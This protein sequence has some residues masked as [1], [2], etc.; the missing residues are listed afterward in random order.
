M[1]NNNDTIGYTAQSEPPHFLSDMQAAS[2]EHKNTLELLYRSFATGLRSAK[3]VEPR[4]YLADLGLDYERIP[5]AFCSG[6]YH[7][8]KT[9]E[10]LQPLVD[11]GFLKVSTHPANQGRKAYDSFGKYALIFPMRDEQERIVSFQGLRIGL[12][13]PKWE[14]L[15][16][17]GLYPGYPKQNTRRLYITSDI[18]D[19]VSLMQSGVMDNRDA[20]LALHRDNT[21]TDEHQRAIERLEKGCEIILLVVNKQESEK[22]EPWLKEK[23]LLHPVSR[24]L[25]PEGEHLNSMLVKYGGESIQQI[26]SERTGK[27]QASLSGEEHP[28]E[29][30]QHDVS[31]KLNSNDPNNLIYSNGSFIAEV[32]GGIQ[33]DEF[34]RLRVVA[35]VE[36]KKRDQGPMEYRFNCDLYH[37]HLIEQNIRKMADIWQL[38]RNTVKQFISELIKALEQYRTREASPYDAGEEVMSREEAM[39][40]KKYLS[41]DKLMER[42]L[43]D[44]GRAGVVGELNNRLLM[45]MV[46]TSRKMK[47]PLHIITIG[48]SGTGKTYL[49]EKIAEFIPEEDKLDITQLSSNAL[50]YFSR[51]ELRNKLLLIEDLDGAQEALY[52]LRELQTKQKLTKTT[53]RK[54]HKGNTRSV[55]YTVEGPVSIAACT[56]R[57]RLY[58]DNANRAIIIHLDQ[59]KEQDER[60]QEYLKRKSAGMVDLKEEQDTR[61]FL[62][63]SQRLLQPI[64]VINPFALELSLQHQVRKPRRMMGI[65][66]ALIEAIA[67]YHQHQRE[68]KTDT[69]G[70]PYIEAVREDIDWAVKLLKD[71]MV[72]RSDDIS[73]EERRFLERT[74]AYL[75]RLNITTFRAKELVV[76]FRLNAMTVNRYLR[77]LENAAYIER[78][79]GDRK[80][81]FEYCIADR[82][83][84]SLMKQS[85]LAVSKPRRTSLTEV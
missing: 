63:N 25:V 35:R 1:D 2:H 27:I 31:P 84:Y 55:T 29:I 65:F 15:N 28:L 48:P 51:G 10:E 11:V 56:T 36:Y 79:G 33:L 24:V 81:G 8:R 5:V 67:F 58:E 45:Y 68:I 62:R 64:R 16:E 80:H 74:K 9:D 75:K 23:F 52:P 61:K 34:D 43:Q 42:T 40:S 30:E 19:A 47:Q 38:E 12:Q 66:L 54:D 3:A 20:V 13:S 82:T 53:V 59:S 73:Y 49:M 14:V 69:D 26:I 70:S 18:I 78:T 50:Y 22:L 21:I 41:R 7:H 32:K 37:H 77:A 71:A 60:V 39:A 72:D 57:E 44:I 46:F 6:Q 85:E 76:D 4:K 17:R 83:E